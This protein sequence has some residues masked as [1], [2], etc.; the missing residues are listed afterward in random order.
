MTSKHSPLDTSV[1]A[2]LD[3]LAMPVFVLKPDKHGVPLYV[4]FNSNARG[5][6]NR[7][8]SDYIGKTAVEVY[9]GALGQTAFARHFEVAMT[10]RAI[11]YELELPIDGTTRF[12]RTTLVPQIGPDGVQLLFGTS[13][14][15]TELRETRK[16]QVSYNT[17][18]SEMEQFVT[19]A[20][21]DLRTPV[22][23]MALIANMLRDGFV[24][25]EDGKLELVE[26]I[27]DVAAKSMALISDVMSHAQAVEGAESLQTFNFAALCRDLCDVIDPHNVHCFTYT[28]AELSTDRAALQIGVRNLID[29]ALR[30]GNREHLNID[31]TVQPDQSGMLNVTLCDDGEGFTDSALDFL[32]GGTF[33]VDSGYG[34]LGVRRMVLARGGSLTA[35][36]RT[37]GQGAIVCLSLPGTWIN[38]TESLG[39]T[40]TGWSP[41]GQEVVPKTA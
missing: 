17:I 8:L 28:S 18:A 14:D 7:P 21:Q 20:A 27:E 15:L 11:T 35:S 16:A 32:N 31:I 30:H 23:Q 37:S 4:A 2:H 3:H 34:L 33:R 29:N 10:G 19:M 39:D 5:I 26:M 24:D 25:H 12:V 40:L 1:F 13:Q 36:N 9:G 6:S 38:A 22:R 41:R